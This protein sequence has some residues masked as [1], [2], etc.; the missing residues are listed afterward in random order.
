VEDIS[1]DESVSDTCTSGAETT[2]S[3]SDSSVDVQAIK[4]ME[5]KG[6]FVSHSVKHTSKA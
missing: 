2:H 4:W 1:V 3:Y 5:K 6:S